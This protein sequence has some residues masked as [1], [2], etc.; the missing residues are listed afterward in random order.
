VD[1]GWAIATSST[2]KRR[3][4]KDGRHLH[5]ILDP[6]SGLPAPTTWRTATVVSRRCWQANALSTAA[7]VRGRSALGWLEDL[8]VAARL[9]DERGSVFV[10]PG[11]PAPSPEDV[12]DV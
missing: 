8:G 1:S 2:Q 4:M 7:I 3:W 10:T 12:D 6:R 5:H 9:V 11:W